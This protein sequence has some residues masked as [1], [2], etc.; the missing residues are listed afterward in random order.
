MP[1]G[2]ILHLDTPTDLRELVRIKP[3]ECKEET[4]LWTF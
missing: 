4:G 1:E 2:Q 3:C